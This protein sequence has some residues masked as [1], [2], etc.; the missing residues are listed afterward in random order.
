MSI[1]NEWTLGFC[2]LN[3]IEHTLSDLIDARKSNS[4]E[5]AAIDVKAQEIIAK[6]RS[7]DI[8]IDCTGCKSLL[9]DHL[10]VGP[11]S[12]TANA[13][14]LNIQLEY[15]AVITFL[16]G[17]PYVCNEYCKYYKNVENQEYKF[18]PAVD[19]TVYDGNISH[20]TGI[21]NITADDYNAM[22]VKFD[23]EWLR[24]NFPKVARSMDRFIEKIKQETHGE[25]IG[26]L[27]IVR[28]PLNLYKAH[29]ATSR[30]W[31]TAEFKDHPFASSPVF[32]LGDAAIG[33]PYFQSISLGFECAMYLAELMQHRELSLRDIFERYE[34]YIYK[35]WLRVYMRSRVIKHNKDMF[36]VI[37]D[38]LRLLELLHIY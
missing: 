16:Y 10:A 14:T 13:N 31:R 19:R 15:A 32:L 33:S 9:R 1:L 27:E 38:P 5:R 22:P 25:I 26:D 20:V 28:I 11:V 17:Q 3:I 29:N 34:H 23:G 12:G 30:K 6:L 2:P 36:E 18:I 8:V 24:G 37:D 4:V 35:Q 21:V 7:E